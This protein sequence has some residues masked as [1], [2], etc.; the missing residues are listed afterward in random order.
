MINGWM[1]SVF[2]KWLVLWFI[3]P[4]TK[5]MPTELNLNKIRNKSVSLV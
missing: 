3:I 2:N 4:L 1:K 5:S